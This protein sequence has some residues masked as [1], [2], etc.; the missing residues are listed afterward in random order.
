V[1]TDFS[2]TPKTEQNLCKIRSKGIKSLP[3][4]AFVLVFIRK[5]PKQ[6][7]KQIKTGRFFS[8]SSLPNVF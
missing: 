7:Q 3:V 4:F 2:I 5:K 6:K 1:S 8:N